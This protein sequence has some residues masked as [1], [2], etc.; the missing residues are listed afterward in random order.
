MFQRDYIL[1]LVE[2]LGKTLATVL[3]LK[4][5]KSWDEA[6]LAVAEA[7]RDLAGLDIETLLALPVDQMTTLFSAAGSLDAGKCLVAAELLCEHGEIRDLR[8]DEATACLERTRALSLL[9]EVFAGEQPGRIPDAERYSKRIDTLVEALSDYP[10]VPAVQMKLVSYY[11]RRGELANAE[12]VL[13]DL[14]DAGHEEVITSGI[15]LYQRLL[16]RRDEELE[17]GGLPRA[18]VEDGLAQLQKMRPSPA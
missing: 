9:L 2:Q 11:E 16:T 8:G 13:F 15:D 14:I 12:D 17:R 10:P 6:E 18:E 7:A 4:R 3:T 5:A 1:R